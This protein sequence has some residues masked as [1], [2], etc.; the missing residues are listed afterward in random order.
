MVKKDPRLK[1]CPSCK[2]DY[3]GVGPGPIK[4]MCAFCNERECYVMVR[5]N[6]EEEVVRLWNGLPRVHDKYAGKPDWEACGWQPEDP[7]TKS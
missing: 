6:D 3:A 1:P 5:A 4:S 7:L 2:D